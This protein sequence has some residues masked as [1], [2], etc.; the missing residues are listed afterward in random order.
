M[1]GLS[2]NSITMLL[3]LV[4]GAVVMHYSLKNI[5]QES[6][7]KPNSDPGPNF[8][9]TIFWKP[10]PNPAFKDAIS[11]P[12]PATCGQVRPGEWQCNCI[13][14]TKPCIVLLRLR[15]QVDEVEE[16]LQMTD[17]RGAIAAQKARK[18]KNGN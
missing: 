18:K 11:I 9:W 14:Q 4:L 7:Q 1:M 16:K 10:K 5:L 17:R 8:P 12:I 15:S 13:D 6:K 3:A 2:L